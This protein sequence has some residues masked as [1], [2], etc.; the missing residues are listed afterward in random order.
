MV[1]F[2]SGIPAT[3]SHDRS[4]PQAGLFEVIPDSNGD[5]AVVAYETK[6]DALVGFIRSR[7]GIY[8]GKR[9]LW[10][11]EMI[12]EDGTV[13][14]SPEEASDRVQPPLVR[15]RTTAMTYIVNRIAFIPQEFRRLASTPSMV[16][17]LLDTLIFKA[18]PIF[19]KSSSRS[20]SKT[21]KLGTDESRIASKYAHKSSPE[22][23]GRQSLRIGHPL[24]NQQPTRRNGSR[25]K[26]LDRAIISRLE[27]KHRLHK[28]SRAE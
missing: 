2:R 14:I 10:I 18:S 7:K 27:R 23:H 5:S 8:L 20:F 11:Y 28:K 12:R 25:A 16:E 1:C 15:V 24:E 22:A 19:G 21:P 26:L 4:Q 9:T 6:K 3:I 17:S 13:N